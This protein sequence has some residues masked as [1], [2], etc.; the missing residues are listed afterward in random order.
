VQPLG[1]SLVTI[2]FGSLVSLGLLAAAAVS[3]RENERRAARILD[4]V[5]A[6]ILA[7]YLAVGLSAFPAKVI[8]ALVLLALPILLTFVLLLPMGRRRVGRDDTPTQRIDERD[9]MF[10]RSRLQP[11]SDRYE[12]YYRENPEK[13]LPDE[14][15]RAKPGLLARRS[16]Y[17][18]QYLF[19]ASEASLAAVAAFHAILDRE[20]APEQVEMDKTMLDH[21]AFAPAMMESAQQY[22]N[23]GA[24]AVQVAEFIRSLGHAARAHIDGNYRVVCPLVA[25]DAGLGEIGR[26]GL[27]MTP[28]L[29]PRVRIAVV[30]T[31]LPLLADS[32]KRDDSVI[33]FCTRC[34]KCASVC[35]GRAVPFDDQQEIAGVRRWQINHEACYT[36]WCAAGTD[37][38]RCIAV[39]PYSHPN[40]LVHS[41][42]RFGVRQSPLFRAVAVRMDDLL[43]GRTPSPAPLSG[44]LDVRDPDSERESTRT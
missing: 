44:W 14:K 3:A 42:V 12:T 37:C 40:T 6:T 21:A 32:R 34:K 36:Y 33:D 1:I 39:C 10:S 29:G 31:N 4:A 25:R 11:G 26:L 41:I 23:I 28:E 19:A 16:A 20:P 30:T 15:F 22:L 13:K 7:P 17:H 9:I 38:G 8:T 35:P 2:T 24:I 5:A 43:Y 18:D 27:L